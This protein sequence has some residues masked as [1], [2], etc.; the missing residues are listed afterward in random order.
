MRSRSTAA[1]GRGGAPR[2]PSSSPCISTSPTPRSTATRPSRRSCS[3]APARRWAR[4]ALRAPAHAARPTPAPRLRARSRRAPPAPKRRARPCAARAQLAA[5]LPLTKRYCTDLCKSTRHNPLGL[6]CEYKEC[7]RCLF[8]HDASELRRDPLAF[9]QKHHFLYSSQPCPRVATHG[10]CDGASRSPHE[11]ASTRLSPHSAVRPRT[12][13]PPCRYASVG[14]GVLSPLSAA[15]AV[16]CADPSCRFAHSSFEQEFHP[17]QLLRELEAGSE[18]PSTLPPHAAAEP[19]DA[20]E[21]L[22]AKERST[23]RPGCKL[24]RIHSI[25]IYDHEALPEITCVRVTGQAS[26]QRGNVPRSLYIAQGNN[27]LH[28]NKGIEVRPARPSKLA[29][30]SSATHLARLRG[31][32]CRA[33]APPRPAAARSHAASRALGVARLGRLQEHTGRAAPPE[34]LHARLQPSHPVCLHLRHLCSQIERLH[35]NIE[36]IVRQRQSD[37]AQSEA[38]AMMSAAAPPAPRKATG[39]SRPP[40]VPCSPC[41]IFH[42]CLE[43]GTT[44]APRRLDFD[45]IEVDPCAPPEFQLSPTAAV[46]TPLAATSSLARHGPEP[47][48]DSPSEAG[49]LVESDLSCASSPRGAVSV[50]G[51]E[52]AGS[53][54]WATFLEA[55]PPAWLG[56]AEECLESEASSPEA[57]EPPPAWWAQLLDEPAPGA[58]AAEERAA[59]GSAELPQIAISH[60]QEVPLARNVPQVTGPC[61][62]IVG[63]WFQSV[64]DLCVCSAEAGDIHITEDE[65]SPMTRASLCDLVD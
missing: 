6:P 41:S 35:Q 47:R 19:V 30:A 22:G 14:A 46:F 39:A 13:P 26:K 31:A 36:Q 5:L 4:W 11:H 10:R 62:D 27:V 51:G 59:H 38:R 24:A 55:L 29:H 2:S 42:E 43:T 54:V 21:T 15:R 28:L 60:I 64:D 53:E 9:F 12:T 17:L 49:Q 33:V 20:P 61:G 7:G 40:P 52:E 37:L 1:A 25:A 3:A 34:Q 18:A 48:P 16:P 65:L 58:E 63:G 32:G 57:A 44:A 23:P 50:S 56:A 8:A 45:G